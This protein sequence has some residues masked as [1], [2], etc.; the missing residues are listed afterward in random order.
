MAQQPI[1]V[2]LRLKDE[3]FS[4]GI[5]SATRKIKNFGNE[6]QGIGQKAGV[7]FLGLGAIVAKS[8]QSFG[9][10]ERTLNTIQAVSDV[11]A[12]EI[13]QLKKSSL[14][15][16]AK[17]IFS[18]QEV[19]DSYLDISKAGFTAQESLAAMP[20]ILNAAAASGEGLAQTAEIITGTLRGFNK[21]A[22]ESGHIADVLAAAANKSA[23][24]IGDLGEAMKQVAPSAVGANQTLEDMAA[25]IALLSNQMIKGS[26]AGTDLKAILIRLQAPTSEA[27]GWMSKLGL[28]IADQSGKVRPFIDIILDLKEKIQGLSQ[29]QQTQV[30]EALAGK[31]NIKS[32]QSLV[33][34]PTDKLLAMQTAMQNTTGAAQ[35]MAETINKGV[36][37]SFE[38]LGGAI[39]TLTS[40]LG[41]SMAPAIKNLA[42]FVQNLVNVINQVPQPIMDFVGTLLLVGTSITGVVAGAGILLGS[43][44]GLVTNVMGL[45]TVLGGWEVISGA[46]IA[47][48]SGLGTVLSGGLL[49]IIAGVVAAVAGLVVA[50]NTDF[51]GIQTTTK[52]AV[53]F[54]KLVFQDL[55]KFFAP[56]LKSITNAF[57]FAFTE[58]GKFVGAKLDWIGGVAADVFKSIS[59]FASGM[60]K[61]VNS[62]FAFLVK[63][64]VNRLKV[65]ISAANFVLK[66]L[67]MP[68]ID[69]SAMVSGIKSATD[70][71]AN[72]VVKTWAAAGKAVT[73][74]MAAAQN[75]AA[76]PTKN[77]PKP[78]ET[79]GV[80]PG[81]T[82]TASGGGRGS[83]A[84]TEAEKASVKGLT[85]ITDAYT[86]SLKNNALQYD[87][88]IAKLSAYSNKTA[89]LSLQ[90]QK[91]KQDQQSLQEAEAKLTALKTGG[92]SAEQ[93]KLQELQEVR[94]ALRQNKS[95]QTAIEKQLTTLAAEEAKKRADYEFEYRKANL[96]AQD[97][98][99]TVQE[100]VELERLKE[101]LNNKKISQDEYN[102]QVMAS[103]E[104][105]HQRKLQ[106]LNEEVAWDQQK[107]AAMY[108]SN[109]QQLASDAEVHAMK[110]QLLEDQNQLAIAAV[111]T[112][113]SIQASLGSLNSKTGQGTGVVGVFQTVQ[114]TFQNMASSIISGNAD[115]GG[116]FKSLAS[117][118]ISNLVGAAFKKVVE[119]FTDTSKSA[120][121]SAQQTQ[122]AYA[123]SGTSAGAVNTGL[124]AINAASAMAGIPIIGP[125]L[126]AAA[127]A[128]AMALGT[129]TVAAMKVAGSAGF[130]VGTPEVPFDMNANIHKGEIIIPKTFA[131]GIRSGQ[132]SLGGPKA[133]PEMA[134]GKTEIN[135]SFEG[136][137]FMGIPQDIATQ[138][139]DAI[140]K[141]FYILGGNMQLRNV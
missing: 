36:F 18:N 106:M 33:N 120:N 135:V 34:M 92:G 99:K 50:W 11:T 62:I 16:G 24:D 47:A 9:Q 23:S 56:I 39:Q 128:K 80:T 67:N 52:K 102:A 126:A 77:P 139:E 59:G 72:Y 58:I 132:L 98:L 3:L 61:V 2:V 140:V 28:S 13:D 31:E 53:E 54:I 116:S 137:N 26:D 1:D 114:S 63:D 104:A 69:T 85:A 48:L 108:D 115:I 79:P 40:R 84:Q 119:G 129:A 55:G 100:Q 41:E 121:K 110:M 101:L 133:A 105:K 81:V 32:L 70:S 124:W 91:L 87:E 35:K 130:A 109:G 6:M 74:S 83:K 97:E 27:A 5:E 127:Y 38:Q 134:T 66:Q 117:S 14:D 17:T 111:R 118:I 25:V 95:E 21:D 7:A 88:S 131:D 10:F 113:A 78:T 73:H 4:Q 86:Q 29:I 15:L 82:P 89:E 93:K 68:T 44:A 75:A 46:V 112:G 71:A 90:I 22:A 12:Q 136:A 123:S 57:N 64:I 37:A 96:K 76:N 65:V 49:P 125:A 103:E 51:L 20:G 8:T 138:I 42:N 94:N 122:K 141:K 107:L 60:A 45:V 19:A 43:I 30:L